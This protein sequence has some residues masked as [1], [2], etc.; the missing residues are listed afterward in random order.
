LENFE[1][2]KSLVALATLAATSAF[3]QV[4]IDGYFDRGYIATN[5]TDN[6]KDSKL[7]GSNAG[8][9]TIGFKVV[10]ALGGGNSIGLSVNTDWADISGANQDST[11]TTASSIQ[12][13]GFA[14]SQ[15]FVHFNSGM[16][17]LRL[18]TP[19]NFTLTNVIAV[20]SPA[21]STGIGSAYSSG[22]SVANGLGT[23]VVGSV[24][25]VN[26]QAAITSTANAGVRAI[27]IANT[28]QY[29][30]PAMNGFTAH[31]GSTFK[32]SNAGTGTD[33]VGV[34]EYA[35]RYTNGP[36]DA[37]YTSIQYKVGDTA[38]ANGSITAGISSKQNLLGASYAVMPT[39]KLHAGFGSTTSSNDV[40]KGTSSQMGVTY[41]MGAFTLMGQ[42]AKFDDT[43]TTNVDRKMI[44]LGL[45]YSL[46]KTARAYV[47]YDSL[48]L[49]SNVA[50]AAG[51]EV[52]RTAV[53]ISKSF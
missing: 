43:S 39:L 49:G 40:F 29:S 30:S 27:R 51:S 52:T 5:N 32:N 31:L 10:E 45:D 23:G 15:S 36:V 18:G 35:L 25:I 17:T 8:T 37:M 20:A 1:M 42:T 2:K 22:F 47:R 9:T 16:G 7:V 41:V 38:P 46:S 3:A 19:N 12:T 6:T 24:G 21:F 48:N 50:V 53:G 34:T 4:T 28:V 11:A 44:G 13:G 26:Q 33:T 14:N